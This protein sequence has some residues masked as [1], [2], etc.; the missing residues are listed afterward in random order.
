MSGCPVVTTARGGNRNQVIHGNTGFLCKTVEDFA[1]A[2]TR[3]IEDGALLGAM[4]ENAKRA[5]RQFTS[6]AV[7][8]RFLEFIG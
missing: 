6:D 7:V 5:A 4:Q 1:T 2:C 8:K 3:L